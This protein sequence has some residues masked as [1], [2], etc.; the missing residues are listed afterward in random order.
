MLW[1]AC[2]YQNGVYLGGSV[3]FFSV[4]SDISQ[5]KGELSEAEAE[6]LKSSGSVWGCDICQ[7]VCPHNMKLATTALGE[8]LDERVAGLDLNDID[9]LSDSEFRARYKNYAFSWRGV[10]VLR[11]NLVIIIKKL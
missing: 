4:L 1:N 10:D 3:C 11:R 2:S 5:K 8:L 7:I 6:L 9:G